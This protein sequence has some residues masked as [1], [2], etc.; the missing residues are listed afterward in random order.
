MA[1]DRAKGIAVDA[2]APPGFAT[3]VRQYWDMTPGTASADAA[4]HISHVLAAASR[5]ADWLG[6]LTPLAAH[7]ERWLDLGCGTADLAVTA[8]PGVEVTSVDIA[9]RWLVVARRRLR[10]S[11][12]D[13]ELLCANAE[14][15]PFADGTFDRV[16]GLGLIEHCTDHVRVLAEVRRVLRPGGFVHL[17]TANRRTVLPEPH[18][19]L[20]G[21]SWLPQGLAHRYVRWRGGTGYQHHHLPSA[22]TLMVALRVV[23][24]ERIS[25]KPA[26]ICGPEL[27]RMSPLLGRAA[28]AY[29][30]MRQVPGL[31]IIV[32][33]VAPLLEARAANPQA[34]VQPDSDSQ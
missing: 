31:S 6:R 21:V 13:S 3:A 32:R 16:I 34:P 19:A 28:S 30:L 9:F 26:E 7:G 2:A 14:T 24:F 8:P 25:V 1:E 18:V 29:T 11:R 20:F 22:R 5:T 15:L 23:G 17:R 12:R 4:R 10:E 27:E 33:F